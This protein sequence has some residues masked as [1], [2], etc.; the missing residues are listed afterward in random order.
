MQGHQKG[1]FT[2]SLDFELY[3]GMQDVIT[4]DAYRKN[5]E[6]TPIAIE[7]MLKHFKNYDLHVTWAI[8]GFLFFKNKEA[9]LSH[10]PS[11]LPA[12]KNREIDL[13][14]YAKEHHLEPTFHFAPELI[15][16]ILRTPH[17]E[18]ASHT[19]S[20]YYC[21]EKGQDATTFLADLQ[22]AKKVAASYNTELE[23]LVFPRNQYNQTYLKVIKEAGFRSYRGNEKGWLYEA[24]EEKSKKSPLRRIGR[25]VDSYINL[26]GHHTYDLK[27]LSKRY[28]YD[29]PASRF[30]RPYTPLLAPFDPLKIGRIKAGM[31][32]A[33]RHGRL[34]HLWWH[35][36]NF[37]AHTDKHLAYLD[38]ILDTYR[39]LNERYGFE[40]LTM[41]EVSRRL[42]SLRSQTR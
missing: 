36:H 37:G 17:Q 34:F 15:K 40:S 26:S 38:E 20:H 29:I 11:P 39:S 32:E 24:L 19:F 12:Y 30:L 16:K 13:Y 22:A 21:L 23:S 35:P 9:L 27:S 14:V 1:I 28:P 8:V 31:Q 7:E 41:R 33:A 25:M 42:D 3:W 6:G 18:V 5:L 2:I 10:L 4:I